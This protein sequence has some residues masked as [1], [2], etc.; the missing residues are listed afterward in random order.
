M[1]GNYLVSDPAVEM[2]PYSTAFQ[3]VLHQRH[4]AILFGL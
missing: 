2:T 1:M 4:W 3:V